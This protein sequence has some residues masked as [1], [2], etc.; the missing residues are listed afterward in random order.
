MG[1][2]HELL[3]QTLLQSNIIV[4]DYSLA[5]ALNGYGI[6]VV[7]TSIAAYWIMISRLF[8]RQMPPPISVW[9][10]WLLLDAVA[11]GAE[12]EK[13]VLNLQLVTYTV[14]TLVVCICL[15][16]RLNRSW[17]K[18]WDSITAAFVLVSIV[19]WMTATDPAW[20]LCFALS[21][22]TIASIPLVRAIWNGTD[23]PADAWILILLG[24]GVNLLDGKILSS[25]WLGGLQLVIVV[26]ILCR[27]HKRVAAVA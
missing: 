17:D 5:M 19:A 16:W 25:L 23:E 22:M 13:G 20:G 1:H 18:W 2:L 8:T 6:L 7:L 24:S 21:G 11:T 10:L 3:F 14:G 4:G 15:L 26:L 9:G 27:K 12:L